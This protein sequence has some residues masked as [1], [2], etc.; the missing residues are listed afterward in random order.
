[1]SP[2]RTTSAT[3]AAQRGPLVYL[4]DDDDA[5]RDSL[6]LLLRSV[7]LD[8]EVYAS[9]LEFLGAYDSTRHSCLVADIRMPGLSGLELQQ[10]LNEQRAEVPVIF[11][12]GHG[13]VPMAVN[14]MKS[15]A[16][17]FIQKPFRDQDL[18]DRIHKALARDR[19]RRAQRVEED[20]IRARLATLTPR[21][22]EVMKRVVRGQANKVIAL[23]LGVSQRTVE[24]HRAR[25]MRKL[26]MRS[27]AEL[28]SSVGK[29]L[30]SEEETSG[31]AAAR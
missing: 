12:T 19:E 27:L 15:G 5:I 16:S 10:R 26:K 30:G 18:L 22:T 28:V 29:M 7:G 3:R 23:D 6:G 2:T 17:D 31:T 9:A 21:E 13:D 1:V 24:L 4:V 8:C 25:V 20:A 11:I 14:A